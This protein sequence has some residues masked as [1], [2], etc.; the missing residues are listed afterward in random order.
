[1][2]FSNAIRNEQIKYMFNNEFDISNV[3][4]ISYIFHHKSSLQLCFIC[5][6]IPHV[7]PEKW[8]GTGFNAMSLVLS[9]SN[10]S[11][12]E[13][14]GNEVGFICSPEINSTH[15]S[16]SIEILNKDFY[17]LCKADFLTID[18]ITPYIDERWD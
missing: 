1:M 9:L 14:K 3:E 10:I 4:F 15:G 18:G 7:H 8:D 5:K 13:S 17:L 6:N 11:S 12:F 16:S 2:W